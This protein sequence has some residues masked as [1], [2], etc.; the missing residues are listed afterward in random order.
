MSVWA[1]EEIFARSFPLTLSPSIEVRLPT[2]A[3]FAAA[4]L[5]A[6]LDRSE[7]REVKDAADL[8]LLL[9][10]YAESGHVQDQLYETEDG[11]AILLAEGTDVPLAAARQLGVDIA[12]VI[13]GRRQR[14]LL[15]R[16][17]GDLDLLVREL[18]LREVAGWPRATDR[19]R[20]LVD[21][22]TRGLRT[23]PAP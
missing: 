18:T 20:A 22:L 21:A 4:K 1:F 8:A 19:R 9:H 17:P 2:V 5:A 7:W 14:E 10:W 16:W 15:A 6:W 11:N 13:G 23:E 3:G 12:T